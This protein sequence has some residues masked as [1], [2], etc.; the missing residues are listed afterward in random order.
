[1]SRYTHAIFLLA[2]LALIGSLTS[3]A[4]RASA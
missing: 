4:S 1:M 3:L 2:A